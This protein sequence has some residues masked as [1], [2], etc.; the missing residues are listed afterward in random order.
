MAQTGALNTTDQPPTKA[1]DMMRQ[2]YPDVVEDDGTAGGRRRYRSLHHLADVAV[3]YETLLAEGRD[4][5]AVE[6]AHRHG[7]TPTTARSWVFRARRAGFLEAAAGPGR[8]RRDRSQPRADDVRAGYVTGL[9]AAAQWLAQYEQRR[10]YDQDTWR[11]L[12]AGLNAI[13]LHAVERLGYN[14]D[15]CTTTDWGAGDMAALEQ[16][17]RNEQIRIDGG[18]A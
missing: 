14:P 5:P 10:G 2:L 4:D 18:I 6:I 3:E 16:L 13:V 15:G 1:D 9:Y 7:S 8:L 17:R 12:R 11:Q